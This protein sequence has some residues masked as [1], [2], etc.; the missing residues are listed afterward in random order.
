MSDTVN[1][2]TTNRSG[3]DLVHKANQS[4]TPRKPLSVPVACAIVFAPMAI[5]GVVVFTLGFN[6]FNEVFDGQDSDLGLSLLVHVAPLVWAMLAPMFVVQGSLTRPDTLVREY[7][8]DELAM[9]YSPEDVAMATGAHN[10]RKYQ[11]R[12]IDENIVSTA[13]SGRAPLPFTTEINIG[14]HRY[15]AVYDREMDPSA[16]ALLAGPRNYT[17]SLRVY[18]ADT[19]A[20][21]NAGKWLV[22]YAATAEHSE[23]KRISFE[24]SPDVWLVANPPAYFPNRYDM[25][26]D[27]EVIGQVVAP[28]K[29][30]FRGVMVVTDHFSS[31]VRA[32]IAALC[33][34]MMRS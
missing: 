20:D 3:Q 27:D 16:S 8:T 19:N 22:Q 25:V 21:T 12:D 31:D 34:Q 18:N 1:A 14:E 4:A 10:S 28:G 23:P 29:C 30:F 32:L 26:M 17:Y 11:V 15:S 13:V 33:Y 24:G 9:R 5:Y 7:F 2:T 6:G